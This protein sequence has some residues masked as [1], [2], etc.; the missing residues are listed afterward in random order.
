MQ[1]IESLIPDNTAPMGD[2]SAIVE[3]I[4]AQLPPELVNELQSVITRIASLPVENIQKFLSIL[5][6]IEQNSDNYEQVVQQLL[7]NGDIQQGDLPPQYDASLFSSIKEVATLALKVKQGAPEQPPMEM[8]MGGLAAYGRKGDTMLAHISPYEA[9]I[10]RSYGGSGTINPRTGLVEYG[11][12]FGS[13]FK[14]I[15]PVLGAVVGSFL[16]FGS[17]IGP[18]IGSFA[19]S[20]LAGN[21]TE[22]AL[23]GAAAAG[24]LGY[25]AGQTT[26]AQLGGYGSEGTSLGSAIFKG[27]QAPAE[28]GGGIGSLFSMSAPTV[29]PPQAATTGAMPTDASKVFSPAP[30][31]DAATS[32]GSTAA[33]SAG[34]TA[35]TTATTTGA[36]DPRVFVN[37]T[38]NQIQ[39]ANLNS[40]QLKQIVDLKAN[41]KALGL[42]AGPND[43]MSGISGFVS[44]NPLP[45]AF[46]LSSL[47]SLDKPDDD[48]KPVV[49]AGQKYRED[50]SK[51]NILAKGGMPVSEVDA[52][53][54]GHL[55]GPGTGT[56]DSIPARLS[57]GEFVMTAKAVR[58]AG[59]GDRK[60]GAR[61]MYE[62][63][64]EFEKRA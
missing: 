64:H 45:T 9:Q 41:Y 47:A 40:D 8:A 21:S 49:T 46:L 13:L 51:Y 2:N 28:Q 25:F 42:S 55:Q 54:G 26:A 18:A 11:F 35:A 29:P 12:D 16:P 15:A 23:W 32:A 62:L 22:D 4:K 50:P 7:Q 20:K 39:A 60:D 44:Q 53:V 57:D 63:M 6:Y 1:G 36:F 38:P 56:S 24:G 58:G 43:W 10:L 48:S 37:A 14:S 3:Q 31:A 33:T 34:S 19:A 27:V 52:R 17:V 5:D 61:R 59:N 30:A